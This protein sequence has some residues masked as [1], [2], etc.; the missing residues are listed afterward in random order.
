MNQEPPRIFCALSALPK[1]DRDRKDRI[2]AQEKGRDGGAHECWE[3]KNSP[4]TQ[5][6]HHPITMQ[7]AMRGLNKS[8]EPNIATTP[9]GSRVNPVANDWVMST[10]QHV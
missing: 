2:Q 4:R 1:D 8:P 6:R 9:L 5:P 10:I 7:R 3:M